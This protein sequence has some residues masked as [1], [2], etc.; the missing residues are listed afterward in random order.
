MAL[1]LCSCFVI[2]TWAGGDITVLKSDISVGSSVNR[3]VFVG[4]LSEL[5]LK[6]YRHG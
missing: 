1:D 6:K 5:F 4:V 3:V 2:L